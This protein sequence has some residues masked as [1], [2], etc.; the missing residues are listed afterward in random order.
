MGEKVAG[1]DIQ[2]IPACLA[3]F[4][5]FTELEPGELASVAAVTEVTRYREGQ[6]VLIEDAEPASSFYVI[7]EG[8]MELVH[9]EEVI[10]I[11]EPGEG[12]GHPSLLTGLAPTFTVRAHEDS[13]CYV[14]PGEVALS[15]FG[16]PAGAG[17]VARTLRERLTRTG[18]VVHGR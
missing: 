4:P 5:P 13:S 10:D 14:I 1:R 9:E 18:H 11:L 16:R 17:F 7:R 12:F 15:L 2:E 6:D 8:S 3:R